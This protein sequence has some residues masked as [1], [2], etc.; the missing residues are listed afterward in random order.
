MLKAKRTKATGKSTFAVVMGDIVGSESS[1]SQRRLSNIFNRAVSRANEAN[2]DHLISPL[3]ITLGDEFQGLTSSLTRGFRVVT[4]LRLGLLVHGIRCRFVLG[5]VKLETKVNTETAWNMMGEGLP[6]ARK[7]LN[8]KV[9]PNAYR[10]S[11]AADPAR[12]QLLD[13]IGLS[14]TS[15][16]EDWTETQLK[17]V[18]MR[19]EVDSVEQIASRLKI[20]PRSVYKVLEAAK[21]KYYLIQKSA[22]ENGMANLDSELGLP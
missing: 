6:Q 21:W 2:L 15:I 3:T 4:E 13:A 8:N 16:E 17:Y 20:T 22:I 18:E 5:T 11:F 7:K 14:L 19:Q 10:F 12:E 1:G 9:D